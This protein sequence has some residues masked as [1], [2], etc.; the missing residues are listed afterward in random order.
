MHFANFTSTFILFSSTIF[1]FETSPLDFGDFY[2]E[3]VEKLL[4]DIDEERRQILGRGIWVQTRSWSPITQLMNAAYF[5]SLEAVRKLHQ[6]QTEINEFK[7]LNQGLLRLNKKYE[8]KN[9]NVSVS[10][11]NQKIKIDFFQYELY[12][13]NHEDLNRNEFSLSYLP[14]WGLIYNANPHNPKVIREFITACDK[15][16]PINLMTEYAKSISVTVGIRPTTQS[17]AL[18]ELLRLERRSADDRLHFYM[19]T[20]LHTECLALSQKAVLERKDPKPI[21][22]LYEYVVVALNILQKKYLHAAK[23]LNQ[24]SEL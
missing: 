16:N 4:K 9:L 13:N 21:A 5:L 7:I 8:D 11:V 15:Y 14:I 18:N 19:L 23:I 1:A 12:H 3:C 24:H 6:N 10:E 20:I 22:N 17:I 2:A